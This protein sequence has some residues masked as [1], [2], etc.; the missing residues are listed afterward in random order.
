MI[1]C[2]FDDSALNK[3]AASEIDMVISCK[4]AYGNP[5]LFFADVVCFLDK[6]IYPDCGIH[7]DY[8]GFHL[9]EGQYLNIIEQRLELMKQKID[10]RL[11][12]VIKTYR[13]KYPVGNPLSDAFIIETANEYI[14]LL[15]TITE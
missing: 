6:E 5:Q 4:S 12:D 11:K 2:Q 10:V 14:A 13:I 15:W 9:K 8:D 1:Y 3:T 7:A